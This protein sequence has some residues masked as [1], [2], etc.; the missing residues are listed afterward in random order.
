MLPLSEEGKV[1]EDNLKARSWVWWSSP[2][3]A[4]LWEALGKE[5]ASCL[6]TSRTVS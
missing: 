4:A 6:W 2:V 3:I 1:Q 5:T